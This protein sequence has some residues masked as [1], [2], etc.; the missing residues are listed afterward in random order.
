MVEQNYQR[1]FYYAQRRHESR[2]FITQRN[3]LKN[4]TDIDGISMSVLSLYYP[5]IVDFLY[6]PYKL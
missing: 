2:R 3:Y 4:K 5:A 6:C 1:R